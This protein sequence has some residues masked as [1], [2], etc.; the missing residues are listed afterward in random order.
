MKKVRDPLDIAASKHFRAGW[1]SF[2]TAALRPPQ[3]EVLQTRMVRSAATPRV[4]NHE[5]IDV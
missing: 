3:E 5:A 4:S 2:E 1:P